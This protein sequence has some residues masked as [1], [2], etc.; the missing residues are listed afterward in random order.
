M[1]DQLST[2]TYDAATLLQDMRNE[3]Q[4]LLQRITTHRYLQA[5]EEGRVPSDSLKTLASQQYHIVSR[6]IQNIAL[7]LSRYGNQPSRKKLNDFLQAE[8]AVNEALLTFARAIGLSEADLQN[9]PKLPE[10]LMFSYYEA[11]LCLYGTDADLITAFYFDAQVWIANALRVSRALQKHYGLS[12][13][14]V[15]FFEM[16][17]NYQPHDDEV[18]PFIQ[19]ALDRGTSLGDCPG[20]KP[21]E[22]NLQLALNRGVTAS[23]IRE[24]TR[25]L[26][27]YEWHFWEAMA[28]EAGV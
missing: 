11:F 17:A 23:Q 7:L 8:F 1:S 9:A 26:L 5:L 22:A 13:E 16:Y 2:S 12:R 21:D 28:K 24:S 4:P 27:E 10:A 15:R 19:A 14:D 18:L 20:C 3:L 6:A 25:L